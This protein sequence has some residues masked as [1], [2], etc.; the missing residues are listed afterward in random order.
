MHFVDLSKLKKIL[1]KSELIDEL[2]FS[3]KSLKY[4]N[5]SELELFQLSM[6]RSYNSQGNLAQLGRECKQIRKHISVSKASVAKQK[7]IEIIE[8]DDKNTEAVIIFH[9]QMLNLKKS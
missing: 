8:T 4:N 7:G 5:I 2:N 1:A 6:L 9:E 3:K